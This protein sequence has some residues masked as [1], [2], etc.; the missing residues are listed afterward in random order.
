M[1]GIKRIYDQP[2]KDKAY[3]KNLSTD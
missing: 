3:E 2:D 1:I